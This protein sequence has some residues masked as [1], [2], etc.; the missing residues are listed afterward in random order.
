MIAQIGDFSLRNSHLTFTLIS[1][2]VMAILVFVASRFKSKPSKF[3]IVIEGVH[4]FFWS[5][6]ESTSLALWKKKALLSIVLTLFIIIIISNVFTIAPFLSS[7]Q[8]TNHLDQVVPLLRS[9]TSHFALPIAL[10][11]FV[12]ILAN[13]AAIIISPIKYVG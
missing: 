8:I 5:K 2:V 6:I 1:L 9:P 7:L 10:G 13:A 3:Q 12:I 11:L 4:G